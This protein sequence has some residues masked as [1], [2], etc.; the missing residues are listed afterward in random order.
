VCDKE[1][2]DTSIC[3]RCGKPYAFSDGTACPTCSQV[4]LV[5]QRV[6]GA[7]PYRKSFRESIK[8][9]KYQSVRKQAKNFAR[10]L[11]AL[12]N[13][14]TALKIDLIIPVP[15]AKRR[16]KKRGFNQAYDLASQ[17]S[18][19]LDKPVADILE[20]T[21][22]TAPLYKKNLVARR[23]QIQGSIQVKTSALR[24]QN[25]RHVLIVDDIYTT[26]T[27]TSECIFALQK[28]Y[29]WENVKFY[30]AVAAIAI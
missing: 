12:D 4:P 26:G 25:I 18:E 30:V 5:I 28:A 8:R 15:L 2:L 17:L 14:L 27:T 24:S 23:Q 9:W 13:G 10:L 6:I 22:E 1:V 20:R 21:I 19:L 29:G 16:F 7:V 11:C 3:L